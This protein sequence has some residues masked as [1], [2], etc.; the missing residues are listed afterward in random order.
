MLQA[1]LVV[2][3]VPR[4]IRLAETILVSHVQHRRVINRVPKLGDEAVC[5][6]FLDLGMIAQVRNELDR[7]LHDHGL[8]ILL[9]LSL[10][11]T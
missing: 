3:H 10:E 1:Q 7:S 2:T 6:R 9:H 11:L 4:S 5:Q 8:V